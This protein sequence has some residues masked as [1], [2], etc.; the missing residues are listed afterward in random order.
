MHGGTPLGWYQRISSL[1][2][3]VVNEPVGA[4]EAIDQFLSTCLNEARVKLLLGGDGHH[5]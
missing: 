4:F 2:D 1:V 5:G 3:A